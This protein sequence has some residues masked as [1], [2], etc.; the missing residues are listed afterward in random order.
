[1]RYV[2]FFLLAWA[3]ADPGVAFWLTFLAWMLFD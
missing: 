2:I 3:A 1:M